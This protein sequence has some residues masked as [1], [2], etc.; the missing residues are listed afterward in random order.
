[1]AARASLPARHT[2]AMPWPIPGL[3]STWCPS[4][5]LNR[6]AHGYKAGRTSP[7]ASPCRRRPPWCH[8]VNSTPA[9]FPSKTHATPHFT[10]TPSSSCACLLVCLSRRLTGASVPAVA[11]G[12]PPPSSASRAIP[13]PTSRLSTTARS[14]WSCPHRTLT[15]SAPVLTGFR[16][17]AAAPP[18][19]R[20][21]RSPATSRV[22]PPPLIGRG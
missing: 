2:P 4:H 14:Q 19:V 18:P 15:N 20:C 22:E 1:M 10:R 9:S 16:A 6:L 7:R 21:R 12:R 8:P 11:A 13:V 3:A 17:P 5:C